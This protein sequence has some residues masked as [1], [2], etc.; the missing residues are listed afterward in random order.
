MFEMTAAEELEWLTQKAQE[1][2]K[3][4]FHQTDRHLAR[5]V[6]GLNLFERRLVQ[7][8]TAVTIPFNDRIFFVG[9]FDCA[10]LSGRLSKVAQTL[11]AISGI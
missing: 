10:E 5:S 8:L 2:P 1:H 9:L 7:S 11:D 6:A 3:K 4:N